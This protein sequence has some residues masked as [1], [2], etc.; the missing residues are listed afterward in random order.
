M[1]ENK[2]R[3]CIQLTQ[4]SRHWWKVDNIMQRKWLICLKHD[5]LIIHWKPLTV[6][7]TQNTY[8]HILTN[9][10]PLNLFGRGKG[11]FHFKLLHRCD[12]YS[13]QIRMHFR[14]NPT[15]ACHHP[16]VQSGRWLCTCGRNT[17]NMN[18][19]N[20]MIDGHGDSVHT[21]G[22]IC[23]VGKSCCWS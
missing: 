6:Q 14:P 11:H 21:C 19:N 22:I 10:S 23:Q 15:L 5:I 17:H 18:K 4:I 13:D 3:N 20:Y 8:I 1:K 7:Y 12:T 9:N 16:L 2:L